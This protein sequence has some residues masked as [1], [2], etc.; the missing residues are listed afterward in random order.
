MKYEGIKI[1]K[2]VIIV[3]KQDPNKNIHQGYIVEPNNKSM[4]ETALKWAKYRV[5]EYDEKGNYIHNKYTDLEG[6]VHT[7]NKNEFTLELYDSASGSTQGG[8][9]SF[10]N[11]LIT[12]PDNKQFIIGINSDILI[13]LLKHNTFINGKCNN[14]V[15][16]GRAKGNVGAFTINMDEYKQAQE[17]DKLRTLKNTTKYIPGDIVFSKTQTLLYI[18]EIEEYFSKQSLYSFEHDNKGYEDF[19]PKD[20]ALVIDNK[21]VKYYCYLN[22][23]HLEGAITDILNRPWSLKL[24]LKKLSRSVLGHIEL[25]KTPQEFTVLERYDE[26]NLRQEAFDS[27]RSEELDWVKNR[28]RSL[29]DSSLLDYTLATIQ[30]EIS[31]LPAINTEI[32]KHTLEQYKDKYNPVYRDRDT[33]NDRDE[34]RDEV[35]CILTQDE[36]LEK[37]KEYNLTL[38]KLSGGYYSCQVLG[39]R[40]EL[41]KKINN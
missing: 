16:F 9:L 22:C 32:V 17:D 20:Y 2:E 33:S 6:I 19:I 13:N 23:D 40:E 28:R 1:Y 21:P 15:S 4:L 26:K 3:E 27:T 41:W 34:V 29:K 31:E 24:E 30:K 12:C 39:K 38:K 18:G 11:C 25:N 8:K 5:Y 14:P 36:Y 35:K 10:W 37:V 7:Y